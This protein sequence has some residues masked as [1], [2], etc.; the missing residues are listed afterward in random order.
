MSKKPEKSLFLIQLENEA[1]AKEILDKDQV[2]ELNKAM[3]EGKDLN[4]AAQA[5]FGQN[6]TQ[7]QN[8]N[9]QLKVKK[10]DQRYYD[11]NN[12]H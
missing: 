12:Y 1:K 2:L 8:E 10:P 7:N 3:I 6:Q 11:A 4:Q 9:K 5:I